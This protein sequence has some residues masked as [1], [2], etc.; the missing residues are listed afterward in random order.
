MFNNNTVQ[1]VINATGN[2]QQVLNAIQ[3]TAVTA[4]K[5]VYDVLDERG[6]KGINGSSGVFW[7]V[8][9][10]ILFFISV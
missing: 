9:A 7:P 4:T 10:R 1:F 5:K 6:L 8:M 3:Q 2:A